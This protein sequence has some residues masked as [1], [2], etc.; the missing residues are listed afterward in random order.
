MY[1]SPDQVSQLL[2]VIEEKVDKIVLPIED[3]V[4]EI[5]L[6]IED[7]VDKIVL[8]DTWPAGAASVQSVILVSLLIPYHRQQNKW[9]LQRF[10]IS[11]LHS[12][13]A[14]ANLLAHNNK[15]QICYCSPDTFGGIISFAGDGSHST[16]A[17]YWI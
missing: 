17:G 11:K 12:I 5:V 3:K 8:P 10:A 7:K 13:L 6:P 14:V 1:K 15:S 4:D 16:L 9:Y 2:K